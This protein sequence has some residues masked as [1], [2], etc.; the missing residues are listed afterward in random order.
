VQSLTR[1][2]RMTFSGCRE[3]ASESTLITDP[4]PV[5]VVDTKRPAPEVGALLPPGLT[6][7]LALVEPIDM[8]TAAAGDAVRRE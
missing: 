6:L 1:L 3:Y 4:D 7:T 8:R 5:P 2:I